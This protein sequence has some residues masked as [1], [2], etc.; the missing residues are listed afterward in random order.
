M[1][2]PG[3]SSSRFLVDRIAHRQCLFGPRDFSLLPGATVEP[4][5]VRFAA[6]DRL[7]VELDC[8]HLDLSRFNRLSISAQNRL[9][10]PLLAG[11]TLVFGRKQGAS[12][13]DSVSLSGGREILPVGDPVELLFPRESFG[14]YGSPDGWCDVR[15]LVLSFNRE[16]T[17]T[18]SGEIRVWLRSVVGG[19]RSLPEGPRLTDQGLGRVLRREGDETS[20]C[21]GFLLYSDT[22]G[23]DRSPA[24][25]ARKASIPRKLAM[26]VPPPHS[27]PR[28]TADEILA[29]RIMGQILSEP[30][31]W[32]AD[33]FG[34]QEWTHFLNR[35]HFLRTVAR[36]LEDTGYER[37]AAFLVRTLRHW[38]ISNPVPLGS[39]GGA[40]TSWETLTAAWR[41]REWIWIMGSLRSEPT[42]DEE[43]R[44]LVLRSIWEH[45][46]S[47]MDHK[48]HP[49]NWIIVEAAALALAGMTFTEFIEA[50][51]WKAE[52]LRRLEAELQKQFFADGVH[53]EISPLY[54]AICLEAYLEVLCAAEVGRIRLPD[55]FRTTVEQSTQYL[56]SLCRPDF[57]WPSLN[58]SGDVAG[59]YTALMAM[60]GKVFKRP[61]LVWIGTK[62]RHGSPPP[63]TFRAFPDAG[64]VTMRS[65][66]EPDAHFLVFR[67]G[68]PGAAHIHGDALSLDI[69]AHGTPRLVDPGITT[70]A[71]TPHT[72]YYRSAVAHNTILIDGEGPSRSRMPFTQRVKP[73]RSFLTWNRKGLL[74]SATGI[75]RDFVNEKDGKCLVFRTVTFVN[76]EYWVIRDDIT[77]RGAH[78]VAVCWQFFPGRI[79]VNGKTGQVLCVD[80]QGAQFMLASLPGRI[81]PAIEI[82]TGIA[83]PP[84]GW[85][86]L[87]GS[88]IP[89]THVLFGLESTLPLSLVW[90]LLPCSE[91]SVSDTRL[92]RWDEPRGVIRLEVASPKGRTDLLT[93]SAPDTAFH[94]SPQ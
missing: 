59:D 53:Y 24:F 85:V 72:D 64:I 32:R 17:D 35:H 74:E 51:E 90:V 18:S 25:G 67:A 4:D 75:C 60:A 6:P 69:T 70:Y 61:D 42:F 66:Y 78:E 49:N 91:G 84:R 80:S 54:H 14:S 55:S 21:N 68:P 7:N 88:D 30:V 10:S 94:D 81:E 44:R 23:K 93:F 22:T 65:G 92:S 28:E 11:V 31:C 12:S 13:G 73:A 57:T 83:K 20:P 43:A 62:G 9:E 2:D 56:A 19:W 71:P 39:N 82:S 3:F 40:G 36:R 29:G 41:L 26:A 1:K 77:G 45:A 5:G 46:R 47:L 27:Y 15:S 48:G 34:M 8:S 50:S 87:R 52:G 89:A 79:E 86:S 63:D 58:D 37:Y 33:P 76:R 38:I 16:K